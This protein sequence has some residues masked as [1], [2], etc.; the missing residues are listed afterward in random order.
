MY[1]MQQVERQHR[2]LLRLALRNHIKMLKQFRTD[3]KGSFF[4]T[5]PNE[6]REFCISKREEIKTLQK[7]DGGSAK[8][9]TSG[10]SIAQL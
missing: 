8:V 10:L 2:E 7:I 9:L 4:T 6:M 1:K 3:P 5:N